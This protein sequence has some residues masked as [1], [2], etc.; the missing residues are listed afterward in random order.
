M[1]FGL[2]SS[3]NILSTRPQSFLCPHPAGA[4]DARGMSLQDIRFVL[5]HDTLDATPSYVGE[6]PLRVGRHIRRFAIVL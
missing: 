5:R 3:V 4:I 1:N 6:N 2:A